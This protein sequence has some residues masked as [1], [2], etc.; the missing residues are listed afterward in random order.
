MTFS[1]YDVTY[2]RK[3]ITYVE[4]NIQYVEYT[5]HKKKNKDNNDF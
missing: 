1:P 2:R 3:N 4:P 5:K